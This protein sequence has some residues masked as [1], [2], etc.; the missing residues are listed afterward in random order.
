MSEKEEERRSSVGRR[1]K[2]ESDNSQG[3]GKGDN[4]HLET[5]YSY[6]HQDM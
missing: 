3:G 5:I 6:S 1:A 2:T 4:Y